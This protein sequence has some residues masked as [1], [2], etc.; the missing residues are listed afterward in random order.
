MTIATKSRRTGRGRRVN[1]DALVSP[2][3]ILTIEYML[4]GLSAIGL[5][6]GRWNLSR[7]FPGDSVGLGDDSLAWLLEPRWTVLIL[8]FIL[9][10]GFR[11]RGATRQNSEETSPLLWCMIFFSYLLLSTLWS[12]IDNFSKPAE[13]LNVALAVLAIRGALTNFNPVRIEAAF[14]YTLLTIASLIMGLALVGQLSGELIGTRAATLGGG[15]NTLGRMMGLMALGSVA[16]FNTRRRIIPWGPMFAAA[17]SLIILSG[18]RGALLS[19]T[20]GL[21]VMAIGYGKAGLRVIVSGLGLAAITAVL[22][23]FS[24]LADPIAQTFESRVIFLTFEDG[25][26]AGRTAIYSDA[27][28]ALESN[29]FLG[30]G[31]GGFQLIGW[32]HYPH[33]LFLE[34]GSEAGYLGILLLTLLLLGTFRWLYSSNVRTVM[35]TVPA[36]ILCLTFAQTRGDIFDNRMVFIFLALAVSTRS[37][38]A[39]QK[40]LRRRS[41][42]TPPADRNSTHPD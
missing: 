15:P 29:P 27:L 39:G 26:S 36:M 28:M 32:N 13:V 16:L 23:S 9:L 4:G 17:L 34:A 19:V 10:A 22:I 38:P 12:P 14:W 5:L 6:V 7:I 33:N 35:A 30:L 21:A 11:K 18:S 40:R 3:D 41:R 20:V 1:Q 31:L 25:Y 24:D 8:Q 42:F 37:K 2:R